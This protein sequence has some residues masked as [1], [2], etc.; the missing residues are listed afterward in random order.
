MTDN[1]VK[2][3]FRRVLDEPGPPVA[4]SGEVLG[5]ARR[6]ARRRR[7]GAVVACS[8]LAVVAVVGAAV[9]VPALA[10]GL[11][12]VGGTAAGD[13]GTV[14]SPAPTSSGSSRPGASTP[15]GDVAHESTPTTNQG[16][17]DRM[18][19]ALLAAVPAGY[20]TPTTGTVSDAN[21]QR[22]E[23]RGTQV[24]R[25]SETGENN[26]QGWHLN[27]STDVYRGDQAGA[28]AVTITDHSQP[29]PDGDICALS[30]Q[31]Q[32]SGEQSCQTVMVGDTRVR[33]SVRDLGQ[34]GQIWYATVFRDGWTTQVQEGHHGM[35]P[36]SA[37]LTTLP[38]TP[39]QLAQLAMSR[40]F[41]FQ[42]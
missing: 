27:A 5:G 26:G 41:Q 17:A 13:S 23:V 8:A 15:P 21:G 12:P 32:G 3:L 37:M 30:I 42:P 16:K 22:Y 14:T 33:V 2:E 34:A 9:G 25:A 4:T 29:V 6:T 11:T 31:H 20:T 1:Q 18:L 10:G 39:R 7:T 28:V 38:Y 35:R 40:A 36:G 24:L 19:T